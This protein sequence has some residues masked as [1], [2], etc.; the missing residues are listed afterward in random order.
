MWLFSETSLQGLIHQPP[1]DPFSQGRTRH[2]KCKMLLFLSHS[3]SLQHQALCPWNC[4]LRIMNC[5]LYHIG[6][7]VLIWKTWGCS[8]CC[9]RVLTTHSDIPGEWRSYGDTWQSPMS[10][11]WTGTLGLL[12]L[13]IVWLGPAA[14]LRQK[15]RI[16]VY[17]NCQRRVTSPI[18]QYWPLQSCCGH[19]AGS[20]T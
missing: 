13:N 8:G 15:G 20:W 19:V 3:L 11:W 6:G 2:C 18:S 12:A 16:S 4:T 14:V 9:C 17:K 5:F 10:L 7:G 1:M